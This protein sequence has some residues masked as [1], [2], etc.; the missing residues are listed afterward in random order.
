MENPSR[1]QREW[2][3]RE[4]N[5]LDAALQIAKTDGW[6]GLTI[7]KIAQRIEYS[8]PMIYAHFSGKEDLLCRLMLMGYQRLKQAIS[9]EQCTRSPEVL[10]KKYAQ[11]ALEHTT[12]YQ[13]MFGLQGSVL[14]AASLS[15]TA[16]VHDKLTE[17]FVSV[18]KDTADGLAFL[19]ALHGHVSWYLTGKEPQKMEF[20][21]QVETLLARFLA[22]REKRTN[23]SNR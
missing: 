23:T 20:L 18:W 6:N 15:R 21:K 11:F 14:N 10:A 19:A 22:F 12:L 5:I 2:L 8:T 1:K 16:Q 17:R 13:L 3:E 4:A 7:R 9:S